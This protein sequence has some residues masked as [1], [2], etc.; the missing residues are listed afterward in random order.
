MTSI[1][2]CLRCGTKIYENLN[3]DTK[4]SF[5]N[6][7]ML[8]EYID[9]CKECEN[10]NIVIDEQNILEFR[11]SVMTRLDDIEAKIN[12]ITYFMESRYSNFLNR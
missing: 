5:N 8:T 11:R 3:D 2:Y 7:S 9:K 10:K 4:N 1:S 12:S 6:G